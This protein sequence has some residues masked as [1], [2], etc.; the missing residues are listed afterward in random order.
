[1]KPVS[2]AVVSRPLLSLAHAARL[3]G[4]SLRT[5]RTLPI[6]IVR[7]SKRRVAIS[8][9]DLDSYVASRRVG[10]R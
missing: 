6:P 9:D 4:V 2:H 5:L 3:L 8:P 10:A 1:M 7:I